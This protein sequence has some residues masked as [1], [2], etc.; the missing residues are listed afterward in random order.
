MKVLRV[1]SGLDPAMGG[2]PVSSLNSCI[3]AQRAGV[4]TTVVYPVDPTFR[5]WASRAARR[6]AREGIEVHAFPLLRAFPA[7]SRRWA[8]SPA[9][10]GWLAGR[11]RRFDLVHAH[12]AWTFTTLASLAAARA[13]GVPTALTPH[14]SLTEFDVFKSRAGV[15]SAKPLLRRLYVGAF[16]LLVLSSELE[17]RDTVAG[18]DGTR[19]AVVYHAVADAPLRPASARDGRDR[20][21]TVGFLGRL[22]EKKNVDLLI[23]A[24][25]ELPGD[26]RAVVAGSGDAGFAEELRALARRSGI[27]DRVAWLGFV[28]EQ[29][30][31]AFFAGID[32]LAMPS[33]YECFG[34]AAAEALVHGVPVVVSTRTGVAEIVRR[35]AC[36]IVVPP[37]ADALARALDDLLRD[38]VRARALASRAQVAASEDLSFA[39]HGHGLRAAYESLLAGMPREVETRRD[40]VSAAAT[41]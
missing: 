38:P 9:L 14:E 6:L 32:V 36:G 34:M 4:E 2:S 26:T 8:V 21:L 13:R 24:L 33:E 15:R 39:A 41:R 23:R 18:D 27:G 31:E 19:A 30:K 22:D 25:A 7:R 40:T 11:V 10:A 35:H 37:S 17:R 3:A 1:L 16:D 5:S 28:G 29:E 12:G 20:A